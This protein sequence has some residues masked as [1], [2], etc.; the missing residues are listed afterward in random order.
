[1]AP[2]YGPQLKMQQN[3]DRCCMLVSALT[4]WA[5]YDIC[6]PSVSWHWGVQRKLLNGMTPLNHKRCVVA[7]AEVA[8]T[9]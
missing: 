3:T 8:Y 1:M 4:D 9:W 6:C 7:V 5:S 2:F